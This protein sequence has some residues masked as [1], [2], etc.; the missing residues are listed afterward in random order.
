MFTRQE[1]NIL[2]AALHGWDGPYGEGA[3]LNKDER[4]RVENELKVAQSLALRFQGIL[5]DYY[6]MENAHLNPL[7]ER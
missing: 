2:Q 5:Y 3:T 6:E 4:D 1:L 7:G